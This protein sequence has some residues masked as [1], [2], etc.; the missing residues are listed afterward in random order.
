[1][2]GD[3][4]HEEFRP[5]YPE[6]SRPRYPELTRPRYPEPTGSRGHHLDTYDH[7]SGF[8]YE[9]PHPRYP[10]NNNMD[11]GDR[12]VFSHV[13]SEAFLSLWATEVSLKSL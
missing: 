13:T 1:M 3:D 10:E 2:A 5:R 6:P 12:Y 11:F 7:R 4:H 9:Q 8:A